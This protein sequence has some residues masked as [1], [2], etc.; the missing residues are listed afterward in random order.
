MPPVSAYVRRRYLDLKGEHK[1]VSSDIRYCFKL[2]MR[3]FL[4]SHPA[5][6]QL[7]SNSFTN[8]APL[9]V[10]PDDPENES[11]A[12]PEGEAMQFEE[13]EDINDTDSNGYPKDE[14]ESNLDDKGE[15][16]Q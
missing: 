13:E 6:T 14:S 9:G 1:V 12:Y 8:V 4:I 7:L 2:K 16:S 3:L 10:D 5:T 15:G 11:L